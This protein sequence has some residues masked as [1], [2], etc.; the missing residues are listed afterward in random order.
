MHEL[1][2]DS[3]FCRNSLTFNQKHLFKLKYW[4]NEFA[5][6]LE[7]FVL[8]FHE[9]TSIGIDWTGVIQH[10]TTVQYNY[11][12]IVTTVFS[13]FVGRKENEAVYLRENL[14]YKDGFM[15]QENPSAV[16]SLRRFAR[17]TGTV[18]L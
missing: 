1:S 17:C 2:T 7:S 3:W 9:I 4:K 10:E 13:I 6:L 18:F 14:R 5:Q 11:I 15:T 12:D 16:Q 8:M